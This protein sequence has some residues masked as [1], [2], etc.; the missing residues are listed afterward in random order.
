M[1]FRFLGTGLVLAV[2]IA[3][4]PAWSVETGGGDIP[5]GTTVV[6]VAGEFPDTSIMMVDPAGGMPAGLADLKDGPDIQ[7][8]VGPS[9][10]LA[11]IRRNGDRWELMEDGRVISGGDLHLS[12]AYKPDGALVAAVSGATDTSL[13]LFGEGGKTTTLL[14]RGNGIAVSPSFSPDGSRLVLVSDESGQGRILL[15]TAEGRPVADLTPAA[16][17]STDPVWSPTGEYIAFVADETD[18]CLIRPDGT[19]LRRLTHDQGRNG[20][21][22]FSPDGRMIVFD[23][24]RDGSRQLF[25]MDLD[26]SNQRPLLPGFSRPQS[27]PV[28]TKNKPAPVAD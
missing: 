19:G 4:N 2:L 11:W 18:I 21:P 26:G 16:Q 17:L 3:V 6:F 13:Y 12:P 1:F 14:I 28:W 27:Q 9:G 23:S 20:R 15:A 5:S 25:V 22:G 8:A 24:D 10:Q 7:P